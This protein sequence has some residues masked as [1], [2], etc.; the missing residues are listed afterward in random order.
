MMR[1]NAY[2]LILCLWLIVSVAAD[3]TNTTTTTTTIYGNPEGVFV[4]DNGTGGTY[5]YTSTTTTT[6]TTT[7]GNNGNTYLYNGR[8]FVYGNIFTF[9]GSSYSSGGDYYFYG[10][11]TTI[12]GG[13]LSPGATNI[14]VAT[15]VGFNIG[16]T[17]LIGDTELKKITS[18]SSININS[19]IS[20]TYVSGSNIVQVVSASGATGGDPITMYG[21]VR[22]EFWLPL[23]KLHPIMYMPELTMSASTFPGDDGEQW[24]ER[25]VVTSP[26]GFRIAD[27]KIKKNIAS[28]NKTSSGKNSFETLDVTLGASETPM[29]HMPG[30]D[31]LFNR[32][33]VYIN[34]MRMD[35][36]Q[37][38]IAN[39]MKIQRARRDVILIACKS[40]HLLI[41]ASP[42]SEYSSHRP[43]LAVRYSH[44]DVIVLEMHHRHALKGL[45]PELWGIKPMSNLTKAFLVDPA[46][47]EKLAAMPVTIDTDDTS[48][49]LA[50]DVSG[51]SDVEEDGKVTASQRHR[52]SITSCP[53]GK[54]GKPVACVL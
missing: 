52:E 46:L 35:E 48:R 17:I 15:N 40:A 5:T 33:G 29:E 25:V 14:N 31:F 49:F 18:F 51:S 4:G 36:M 21:D 47:K 43:D 24:F 20:G 16:D 30:P 11:S 50:K 42:A 32:M 10:V 6:T 7:T 45:L 1:F 19:G 44:V 53:A 23:Y 8:N 39:Q 9:S 26:G 41:T 27:I 22:R 3:T 28:F 2:T 34:F 13:T 38:P 12:T 54:D 37:R